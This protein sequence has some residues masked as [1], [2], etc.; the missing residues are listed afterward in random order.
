METLDEIHPLGADPNN[1]LV[2]LHYVLSYKQNH[3]GPDPE[4]F[5]ADDY[6]KGTGGKSRLP[7]W[8]TDSRFKFQNMTLEQ[9]AWQ[10]NVF[11][12]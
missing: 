1:S 7:L 3:E 9:I 12:V 5:I 11:K 6:H 10:N 4:D 8:S 2:N